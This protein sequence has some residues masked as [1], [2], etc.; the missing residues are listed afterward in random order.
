MSSGLPDWTKIVAI[1]GE[2]AA[3]N[4]VTVLLDSS[5]R[6]VMVPYGTVQV[7]GTATVT[8]SAK[9]REIQGKDGVTLRTITVDANGQMI[10]VPRGQ[11]GNYMA[12]DAA[13]NLASV[14]KGLDGVTLRTV[15]VDDAGNIIGVLKGDYAGALK[16][17]ALDDHGRILAVLTDPEDVFGNPHYLGAAELAVRLGSIVSY[18]RRGQVIWMD[19]FEAALL[20]WDT[21]M[22]GVGAAVAL[23]TASARNGGQSVKL[24]TGNAVDD[25]ASILRS[26][27]LPPSTR[28]GVECSFAFE[29]EIKRISLGLGIN[30]GA[31]LYLPALAYCPW[32]DEL[33]YCSGLG[34]Y[35]T[36]QANVNFPEDPL[37]YSTFK[38]V[39]DWS[40]K[41]YV[42]AFVN[43][44]LY[45]LSAYDMPSIIHVT[46]PSLNQNVHVENETVGNHYVYADDF[47]LTENEPL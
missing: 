3:G 35:T 45:D 14:M 44:V 42:R 43:G 22:Y 15:A 28:L 46:T 39:V 36:F 1:K 41:K 13:G 38:L 2:D 23:S 7:A 32:T 31:K 9:D 11:S 4:L 33:Q 8:Q 27:Y 34:T 29:N 16:T 6:I 26:T 5:G 17:L 10:M 12:V 40:T 47:I 37:A 25:Y 18:E 21:D 19:D 24:T 30:D 20:K